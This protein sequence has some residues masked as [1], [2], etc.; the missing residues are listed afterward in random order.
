MANLYTLFDDVPPSAAEHAA[1]LFEAMEFE[2]G[3]Q[4]AVE[5]EQNDAMLFIESGEV[6]VIAGGF[7]VARMIEGAIIGEIGLFAH[8]V[9][10]ATVRAVSRVGMQ[11][12]TRGRF[13]ELRNHGNPIAF[14]IERRAVQ[15]LVGRVR[16]LVVDL[17]Q[18]AANTPSLQ[19][20]MPEHTAPTAEEPSAT[21]EQVA[22]LLGRL[23]GFR[24]GPNRALL[25]LA[26]V[27]EPVRLSRGERIAADEGA[28][29]VVSGAIEA[30]G[31]AEVV[32]FRVSTANPG[33]VVDL[34]QHV[35]GQGRLTQL[36]ALEPSEALLLPTR[37]LT[38]LLFADDLTGSTLR[39]AM[40]RGLAD[41]VNQI[42]GTFSLA[43]L[44]S[45]E[46]EVPKPGK[47]APAAASNLSVQSQTTDPAPLR[48]L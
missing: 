6:E 11:R 21:V 18:L 4:V 31:E 36:H 39:I 28:L 35:D 27:L 7:P 5:G 12:L 37:H 46:T 8:A 25:E 19:T 33:E 1:S 17:G 43:R 48:K 29:F 14:R 47:P 15:Q 40:I 13:V 34:V 44:M 2:P 41:Q 3:D 42:N 45:P 26:T 9:R 16:Q 23:P 24:D 30:V 32:A 10:T 38:R 22:H 20:A